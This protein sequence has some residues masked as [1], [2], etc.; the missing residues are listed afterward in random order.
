[1]EDTVL[2][3]DITAKL[4]AATNKL[5]FNRSQLAVVIVYQA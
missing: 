4:D 1:V 3:D 2:Y 5:Y